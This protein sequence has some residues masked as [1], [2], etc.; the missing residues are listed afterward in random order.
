[1]RQIFLAPRS[2]ETAYKN[3]VSSMQGRSKEQVLPFLNEQEAEI[4]VGN[5]KFFIW[6]CQPSMESRWKKM[7]VGDYILFYAKGKFISVGQLL[8]KKKSEELA[9][10]LWPVSKESNQPWSCVFFVNNL[11]GISVPIKEFSNATGYHMKMVQGFTPVISGMPKIIKDYGSS[12][13]F[14]NSLLTGLEQV[15][16]EELSLY[17]RTPAS[18][19]NP[20][21][22]ERI[23]ELTRGRSDEELD[24]ALAEYAKNA[25][26]ATPEKIEKTV[27]TFKRNRS[28]VKAIKA[29]HHNK[30]QIC[31]FTFKMS[32][33]RYYSEAAHVTPIS[34][35]EEGVDSPDN[36]WV[37]CANHHKML[38][39]HAINAISPNQYVLD[40]QKYDLL[41]S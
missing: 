26:G 10:S 1:M 27:T 18:K 33:G 13:A 36:I 30:C 24:I 4:L 11:Q 2:N 40:G 37:L 35:G 28:M 7:E 22:K 19:L 25:E 38:D 15:E 20:E 21:D 8:Y 23:D 5:D 3:Y 14:I 6:G 34:S 9:K 16:L 31:A 12:E 29:K 32:N 17:A 41:L 39:T